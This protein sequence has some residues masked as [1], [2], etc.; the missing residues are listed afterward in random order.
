MDTLAIIENYY[1]KD[2]EL[3]NI[4][5]KH[6][7]DVTQKA[8]DIAKKHPEL[9]IDQQFVSQAGM[10]HDIGIFATNA[11]GIA[12]FGVA[13][14]IC[15]GYLGREILEEL[16]YH[17]HALV[18]ERHTG[19]GL[20]KDEIIEQHLPLPH[21]DMIP[22]SMEEKV[23]CFADCFFSKTKLGEKKSVEKVRQDMKKYGPAS[24]DRFEELCNLFL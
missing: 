8:L 3:Y 18:C 17:K 19:S 11:P 5:V 10:L 23:I 14:Y 15:H 4:L 7:A 2:S 20:T 6:S 16:G 1:K 13:P 22:I 21:H 24:V 12:C 9:N